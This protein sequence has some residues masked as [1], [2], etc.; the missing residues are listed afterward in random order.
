[1]EIPRHWRLKQERLAFIGGICPYCGAK[2]FPPRAICS[3]CG[4]HSKPAIEFSG[5]GSAYRE[6]LPAIQLVLATVAKEI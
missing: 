2:Q 1:M 5:K 4:P 6:Y 3:K